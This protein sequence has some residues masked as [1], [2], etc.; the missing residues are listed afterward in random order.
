MV[1]ED[2]GDGGNGGDDSVRVLTLWACNVEAF[3]V[4]R[5]CVM[6][7]AGAGLSGLYWLGISPP[8][9]ESACRLLRVPVVR[10][11]QVASDVSYMG[12][13]VSAECNRRASAGK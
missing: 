7:A 6:E 1:T 2:F 12:S 11:A 10:R 13:A 3:A 9:I 4:F 5:L 8:Q